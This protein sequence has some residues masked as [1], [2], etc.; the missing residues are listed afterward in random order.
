M[1]LYQCTKCGARENTA[2]GHYWAAEEGKALCSEC[3]TGT[4]HGKFPKI[5]LP[6]GMFITDRHGNLAHKE[7]GD[8]DVAKYAILQTPQ[9]AVLKSPAG[10][11]RD[12]CV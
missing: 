1:S 11:I 4:W 2:C 3:H 6:I 9:N 12:D 7:T 8:T 5:I 10:T